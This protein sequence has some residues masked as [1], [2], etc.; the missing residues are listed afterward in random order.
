MNARPGTI[1]EIARRVS[2]REDRFDPAV[3]EFLD[4]WQSMSPETRAGAITVEPEHLERVE[5][6][7][8][9]ALTE[10]LASMAGLPVPGWTG[11]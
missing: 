4:S 6:A 8:L 7:Y 5:D 9:A 3:R 11:A 2:S 1:A 10:H